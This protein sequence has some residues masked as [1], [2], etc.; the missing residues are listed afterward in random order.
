ML[1][2]IHSSGEPTGIS[3][4][5]QDGSDADTLNVVDADLFTEVN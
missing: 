3:F 1:E 5:N 4:V 2:L